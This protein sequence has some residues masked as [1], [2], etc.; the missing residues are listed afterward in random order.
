MAIKLNFGDGTS[1]T[2]ETDAEE[3]FR[4]DPRF[5]QSVYSDGNRIKQSIEDALERSETIRGILIDGGTASDYYR[6]EFYLDKWRSAV[7]RMSSSNVEERT[8]R[9]FYDGSVQ[10]SMGR[11][12]ADPHRFSQEAS[13]RFNEQN[14]HV[15]IARGNIVRS[16]RVGRPDAERGTVS[17]YRRRE[18]DD[19]TG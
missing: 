5:A 9:Y 19:Y 7:E 8:N 6:S 18:D 11:V 16:G 14:D 2:V 10:D 12:T 4:I 3:N 15:I 1:V 13:A 17:F